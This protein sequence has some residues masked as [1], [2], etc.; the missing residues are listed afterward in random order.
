MSPSKKAAKKQH[1]LP[2]RRDFETWQLLLKRSLAPRSREAKALARWCNKEAAIGCPQGAI[3]E[4]PLETVYLWTR[5]QLASEG[6][7]KKHESVAQTLK[8]LRPAIE[9]ALEAIKACNSEV[10]PEG[11]LLPIDT[12]ELASNLEAAVLHIRSALIF[13]DRP[14]RRSGDVLSYCWMFIQQLQRCKVS[15]MDAL[16]LCRVLM[17]AHGFLENEL[18]VFSKR[19]RDA[20]TVRKRILKEMKN[21]FDVSDSVRELYRKVK[22]VGPFDRT[23]YMDEQD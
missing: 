13:L 5:P 8:D 22:N 11:D 20:G 12:S 14:Y 4:S 23:S 2:P 15:E 19:S 9:A 18:E 16:S 6:E 10:L 1:A 21:I 7:R 3:R 17:K